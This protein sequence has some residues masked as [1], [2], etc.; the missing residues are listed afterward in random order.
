MPG[1]SV[2]RFSYNSF[3]LRLINIDKII[4]CDKHKIL[5]NWPIISSNAKIERV[6]KVS[7]IA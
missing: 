7:S 3:V 5:D 2:D 4:A 6:A 1:I